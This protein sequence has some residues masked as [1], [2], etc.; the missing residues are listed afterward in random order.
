MWDNWDPSNG[1]VPNA[2]RQT[3]HDHPF[4]DRSNV[5][6]TIDHPEHYSFVDVSNHNAQRGETHY[7]T[8]AFVRERLLASGTVRPVTCVKVYGADVT[9]QFSGSPQDG[10]ER[11]WRNVFAGVSAVRFHRPTAGLGLTPPAQAHI[12]AMRMLTDEFDVWTCGP[13]NNL[14]SG[15]ATNSSFCLADP[16]HVYAVC[17]LDGG[18]VQLDCSAVKGDVSVRWLNVAECNW[19]PPQH[20]PAAVLDLRAPGAG[21]WATL[22]QACD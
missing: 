16:G 14:L 8:A 10:L 7:A 1:L 4:L 17:F 19:L 2:I 11:F 12:R 9:R 22:V 18:S 6:V 3:S 5:D 21:F 13:H 15:R 20:T